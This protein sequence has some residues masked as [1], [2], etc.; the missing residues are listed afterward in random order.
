MLPLIPLVS[1]AAGLV[2][3]LIGLFGGHR[4]GEVAGKVADVVRDV[5]G[6]TDPAKAAAIIESDPAEAKKLQVRLTEVQQEYLKLQMQDAQ[7]ERES[8]LAMFK[9][10]TEDRG[11]AR[12]AMGS[13]LAIRDWAGRLVAISPGDR[14]GDRCDRV[15]WVHLLDGPISGGQPEHDASQCRDRRARRRLHGGHQFLARLQP[16]LARQGPYRGGSPGS[17]TNCPTAPRGGGGQPFRLD[18]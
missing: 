9:A 12:T 13:A 17:R 2:P 16:G 15:L 3:E 4:A 5:T 18:A 8:L 11:N 14:L 6:T 10:E 7:N 1:L